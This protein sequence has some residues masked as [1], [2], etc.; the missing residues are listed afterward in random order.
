MPSISTQVVKSGDAKIFYH[1]LGEGPPVILLHPFPA[2]HELWLP[3]AEALAT[4]YRLILPDLRGH[5]D[6]E[7]GEGPA[8]M[9][10]HAADIANVMDDADVG[11]A[12]LAGVS[13]GGYALFE[14]WRRYRGR[15]ASLILVNT[16][17]AADTPEARTGRM[18]VAN[19]VLESGTEV[20]FQSMIPRLLG[21][22]TRETRPDLVNGALR[23]MRKMSPEDVAQVQRG[24]AERP[25]SIATLKTINVP[26]MIL[27][28]DEDILTG[29]NEAEL[30]HR[31]ISGSRLR[32]IAKA[33][34]YS[35]WEQT[36]EV[37][38]LLR[39]FLDSS[40]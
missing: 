31:Q 3:V 12:P 16:K 8:T 19:E 39:V 15:A 34:H 1:V 36:Q 20:F 32:L 26:T 11:R 17:A 21:K 2:N 7:A 27:T 35:P 22:T 13:I 38:K 37:A 6:S 4:R 29:V 5:G 40:L 14:F 30:M 24:M 18:Q 28:G 25:D 9:E 10:K 23:M 33:G